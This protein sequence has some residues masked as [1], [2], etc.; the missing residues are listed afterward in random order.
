MPGMMPGMAPGGMQ[1]GMM[2]GGMQPGMGPGGLPDPSGMYPG[3]MPGFGTGQ[4]PRTEWSTIEINRQEEFVTI[5]VTIV[6]KTDDF[7]DKRVAPEIA[8]LRG[9]MDMGSGRLRLPELAEAVKL[10]RSSTQDNFPRAALERRPDL[11]RGPR[12]WPPNERVSWLRELLPY[13]ADDRY[14]ELH[15]ELDPEKSWRDPHNV[16][17][18]RV[19]V[20]PFLT[21]GSKPYYVK[22][23]GIDQQLAVTHFVGMA[24]I[25][26]DAPY[27]PKSDPRA[28]ILGYDRQTT[29]ADVKDG[30]SHTILMIQTDPAL[31]G[32]WIAGGG[33]TV[34]GTS[35]SGRDVGQRGGFFSPTTGGKRGVFVIMGD[36]STRFLSENIS[37]DVFKALCTMAGGEKEIGDLE[38]IAPVADP[39][40]PQGQ[41]A[42]KPGPGAT[43][44][45]R[46]SG[47]SPAAPVPPPE[48]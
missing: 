48:K 42:P 14:R 18:G 27:Y 1:P 9:Q 26:P 32:P 33:A 3:G 11:S 4:L 40:Q 41:P 39:G 15:F 2:P 30:L 5:I 37:P 38:T 23:R 24:G 12:P 31:A 46:P 8:Y 35:E 20:A 25:G 45:N 6:D 21:P 29:L 7:V 17:V 34:R 47:N 13:L 43:S 36:G 28:G 19:L 22:A 44:E 16:K 10:F